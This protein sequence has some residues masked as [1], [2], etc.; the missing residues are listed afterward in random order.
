LC[1]QNYLA[2]RWVFNESVPVKVNGDDIVFRSSR[3]DY[4]K[5]AGFVASVGLRLSPG[6]TLVSSSFFSLNSTFF[7]VTKNNVRL[8]P[9]VRCTS[10]MRSKSPYPTALA[11]TMR[12]FLEGFRG[13]IK[14]DLGSWF[15]KVRAKLIRKCGRS[16]CRGLGIAASEWMLKDSGL[17]RREL[18]YL[19][20]VP[21]RYD[22]SMAYCT[23][24]VPLPPPPDRLS[25]QVELPR[26]WK[27]VEMSD[28]PQKRARQR[29]EEKEFWEEVVDRAWGQC[30]NPR[31]VSKRYWEEVD[32]GSQEHLYHAWAQKNIRVKPFILKLV[33]KWSGVSG[34]R[35]RLRSKPFYMLPLNKGKRRTVWCRVEEAA[36]ELPDPVIRFKEM[37]QKKIALM[38]SMET[39]YRTVCS[40]RWLDEEEALTRYL[41]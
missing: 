16:V 32:R 29:A 17:W 2:F 21:S 15:L 14:D 4:E 20:S 8:V 3:E 18:W 23:E 24:G 25:G 31:S 11:G 30:Y 26:G 37:V 7:H 12:G 35:S 13:K 39:P 19:N 33:K 36:E 5:W 34:L 27:R 9:V 1:L 28:R 38:P 6:K 40:E 41:Q 22:K 10:L